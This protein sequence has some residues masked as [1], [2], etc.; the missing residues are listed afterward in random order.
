MF[1]S[2]E[3]HNIT[4]LKRIAPEASQRMGLCSRRQ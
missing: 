3:A 1:I 2:I 4:P